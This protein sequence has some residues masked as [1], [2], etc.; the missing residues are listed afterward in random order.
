M[1]S[2][3]HNFSNESQMNIRAVGNSCAISGRMSGKQVPAKRWL[4]GAGLVLA[5]EV[6]I[7]A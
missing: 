7:E 6:F 4:G 3:H 5:R 2:R 1:K